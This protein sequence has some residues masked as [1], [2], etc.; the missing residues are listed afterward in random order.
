[1]G[2]AY[3][4]QLDE[5]KNGSNEK[6]E[7]MNELRQYNTEWKEKYNQIAAKLKESETQKAL[8]KNEIIEYQNQLNGVVSISDYNQMELK[9]KN[10]EIE[11]NELH[12]S[13]KKG[14]Q[15]KTE[16]VSKISVLNT[17]IKQLQNE[18]DAMRETNM[19]NLTM[20]NK[21][22]QYKMKQI[23]IKYESKISQSDMKIDQLKDEIID[24]KQ[25]IA[26]IQST[27]NKKTNTFNLD[28]FN[29]QQHN[30]NDDDDVDVDVEEPFEYEQEDED[31]N[32]NE[33]IKISQMNN[34]SAK[35]TFLLMKARM[36]ANKSIEENDD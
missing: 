33:K 26:N 30:D 22:N 25:Q 9:C 5:Y 4:L 3:L 16:N 31:E 32:E 35:Q 6:I 18:I 20:I 8:L 1:M 7:K 36:A 2:N 19:T 28:F 21:E 15:S 29:T 13:L 27:E 17:K 34:L 12:K 10:M 11:L 23:R 14:N 24:L